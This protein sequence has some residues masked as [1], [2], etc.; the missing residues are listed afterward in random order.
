MDPKYYLSPFVLHQLRY[1]KHYLHFLKHQSKVSSNEKY[2]QKHVG[3]RCFIIGSGPSMANTDIGTLREEHVIALNSFFMNPQCNEVLQA[4]KPEKYYLVPP[5]HPPQTA[6]EWIETLT[7]MQQKIANPLPMFWGIDYNKNHWRTLIEN[8]HLFEKFDI[9]YFYCGINTRD[10]YR[11]KQKHLDLG[12]MT[13]S[14]S[15]ALV[16]ALS[17]ALYMGFSEV[18]L[19]GFEHNHICVQKPEE[20]RAYHDAAH[21]QKELDYDFGD[22]RPRH[23]NFEILGNN[24]Y[25]FKIYLEIAE[26]FPDTKII[27]CTPGGI[28]DV[29]PKMKF[30]EV[31]KHKSI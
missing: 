3:K 18:Y 15:N 23:I 2:F 30:E 5:N 27:N 1:A 11:L 26:M 16:N 20:Y 6:T 12:G 29:F 13:L 14:A 28:L 25:T 17:L 7:T 4:S 24:Y 22:Q 8:N 19:L 10:G 9:N 21:Y 31:V